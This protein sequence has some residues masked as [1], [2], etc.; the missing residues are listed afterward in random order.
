VRKRREFLKRMGATGVH[1]AAGLG[2]AAPPRTVTLFLCGDVMTGRGIDQILGRPS[3]PRIYEGYAR[4]AIDYIGFAESRSGAIPRAVKPDY[5]WGDALE[6]LDRVRPDVRIINLETSITTS[7][8]AEPKG[9]NYRMQPANVDCLTAAGVDCCVLANNHVLDWGRAGLKESLEVLRGAKIQTAGAGDTLAA[10][11]G[12]AAMELRGGGRVLV[13]GA[14]GPDCGI[15]PEWA[16][17]ERTPGVAFIADY[18]SRTAGALAGRIEAAKRPGDLVVVSVHWGPNWGYGVP[19]EH[20][21]F[22]RQLVDAGAADIV[23]GHSS[24][25]VKGLEVYRSRL[26]LYG[27]GD[28]LNDYEGIGGYEQFRGDLA[29]MYFPVLAAASGE[30]V[31][32][33]MR[34]VQMH[35][36]RLRRAGPADQRWMS[37]TLNREGRALG[38]RFTLQPDGALQLA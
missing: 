2:C 32:L 8:D 28:F 14:G 15:P 22:A 1:L 26:I 13:F 23:H 3:D 38:T 37:D 9:I 34:C 6:E 25:H 36:F 35:R 33:E 4:S 17:G 21:A 24:H 31:R 12:A 18:S 29:L 11:E 20:R 27:C 7:D 5:I 30:L 10:A 19:K 16:A